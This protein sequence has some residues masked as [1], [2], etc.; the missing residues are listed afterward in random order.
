MVGGYGV[1]GWYDMRWGFSAKPNRAG[2]CLVPHQAWH[3]SCSTWEIL[4]I[5]VIS[6]WAMR[7][8]ICRESYWSG[9]FYIVHLWSGAFYIVALYREAYHCHQCVVPT[10]SIKMNQKQLTSVIASQHI[11]SIHYVAG[12][13]LKTGHELTLLIFTIITWDSYYY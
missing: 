1:P 10:N 12:I 3:S 5:E 8:A 11:Y 4:V 2:A 6:L 13:M 9:A 7:N